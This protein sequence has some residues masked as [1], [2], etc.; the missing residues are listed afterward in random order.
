MKKK[1]GI[2]SI[3][4]SFLLFSCGGNPASTDP[5]DPPG[6]PEPQDLGYLRISRQTSSDIVDYDYLFVSEN[7]YQFRAT[8]KRYDGSNCDYTNMATWESTN[9]DSF[10]VD[11]MGR[12]KA[13][14]DGTGK[15]K[16]TY[17]NYS[18]EIDITVVTCAN[19]IVFDDS[20]LLDVYRTTLTYDLPIAVKPTNAFIKVTTN[21]ENAIEIKDNLQFTPLIS[22]E[23]EVT[24]I[25]YINDKGQKRSATFTINVVDNDQPYFKYKDEKVTDVTIDVA[26]NKYQTLIPKE[27][28]VSAFKGNDDTDISDDITI[29]SGTYDLTKVGEYPIVLSVINNGVEATLNVKLNMTEKEM[30]YTRIDRDLPLTVNSCSITITSYRNV[31]VDISTTLPDTYT[32]YSGSLTFHVMF[33][34]RYNVSGQ[35]YQV[36]RFI[37]KYTSHHALPGKISAQEDIGSNFDMRLEDIEADYTSVEFVGYGY[38]YIVYPPQN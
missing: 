17:E 11:N 7:G 6:P 2:I 3:L 8:G 34:V 23:I 5:V 16:A 21:V 28:G 9:T 37:T 22:G 18:D 1:A 24:T 25:A 35:I 29:K 36:D 12:V 19:Y 32:D 13:I 14:A 31:R 33:R 4:L 15:L 26:I 20:K 38:N 30:I 10:A 27:I